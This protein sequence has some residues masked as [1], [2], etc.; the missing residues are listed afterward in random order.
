MELLVVG[1]QV[2][3][4]PE[5]WGVVGSPGVHSTSLGDG[6]CPLCC[7]HHFSPSSQAFFLLYPQAFPHSVESQEADLILKR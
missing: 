3:V 5:T 6:L 4:A 1:F 2:L 7:L